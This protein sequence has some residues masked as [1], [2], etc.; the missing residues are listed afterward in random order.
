M[1]QIGRVGLLGALMAFGLGAT[2]FLLQKSRPALNLGWNEAKDRFTLP[3][4]W[5]ITPVGKL[6][7]LPGDMPGFIQVMPDG[8]RA[9]VNTCGF[10]DQSLN[11]VDLESG[12]VLSTVTFA[13][14]WIGLTV[15]GDHAL[16]SGGL[17]DDAK[18]EGIHR[19]NI[20]G[21]KLTMGNGFSLAGLEPKQAYA[22]SLLS[23]QRGLYAINIQSD[24]VMKLA[25][26][27]AILQQ[28]KVGY[29][30]YGLA[31]SPDGSQLAVSN[32]GDV[33]VSLLNP[34]TL[35]VVGKVLVQS[36]PTA[37]AYANDGRLFVANA[38]ANTVSVIEGKRVAEVIRTGI[39]RTDRIGSTPVAIVISPNQKALYV[40]NAGNNCVTVVDI[41]DPKKS[42]IAGFIPTERYPVALAMTPDGSKLVVATAKGYYGP[43]A[44]QGAEGSGEV[45][46]GKK[47]VPFTYIGN[48]L[49]GRLAIIP[50]PTGNTLATLTRKVLD[51]APLGERASVPVKERE[52]VQREV[53]SKIKH[54]IY[55]VREN[56]TYD[57]VM[58]D[59]A[60]GNGDPNLTI[61]GAD[62]TPNGHKL[63]DEFTLLDNIF[64][65][66][67]V[68]Q[69][70]H[71]WTD[72]AYA[73]DYTEK[74]W[75][76]SYSRHG[77]VESDTRLT[78]SPGEYL[79]TLA[80]KHGLKARVY[81]EYVNVQED[82]NSLESMEIKADPE[83]YGF[84]ASFEEIFAR[85]G[86]DPEKVADFL[87]EM[88]VAEA[89][90]DWPNVMVMALNEDH[91]HGF[92]A[93]AFSPRAMV[94]SNDLALGQLVEA[95]SKS[96]FWESTAIFVI[97]DDAQSG[98]DHVDSHRTVG[99]VISAYTR[100]HHVDSTH[101]TTSS[102]LRTMEL[103]VGLP[104]MTQYDAAATP[105]YGLFQAD[106][107]LTAFQHLEPRIDIN[108]KNPPKTELAA[109]SAKLD[110]S[111]IDR[112]DF[113]ALN[114]ILW[115][116]YRPGVQYPAPVRA[117]P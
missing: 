65:D 43:N 62:T 77:E 80:R 95:V 72:A 28:V 116:G 115:D 102:M 45:A 7:Q 34:E 103:M 61:F 27:G 58:G 30:P 60:Q 29:R 47:D 114:H 64:T 8:K 22:S 54:V 101:Y 46:P 50:V 85:H 13:R 110:F 83:K 109:R 39:D 24:E 87:K 55:V 10:H 14:S 19:V 57:Q 36:H 42:E 67:E 35:A 68:S 23:T 15:D 89:S 53:F 70:G 76:L 12:K 94:G 21:E 66:G 82:H 2:G 18:Y 93:G 6:V 5:R 9:L 105:M 117:R 48:Q 59:A 31:L 112:A 73:N 91:T 17:A 20:S 11:L 100:R 98:P 49:E 38:G 88:K 104:P 106:S 79:W 26:D 40:A 99:H 108:E 92:S 1:H 52:I 90:G 111:D 37:L 113:D 4:G 32:W 25:P 16:V 96:R 97:E 63:A 84:S 69:S 81:G 51:N 75:I 3:N 71:Q 33:S 41:H 107:D 86:R 78:S 56:R 44:R 74:Q